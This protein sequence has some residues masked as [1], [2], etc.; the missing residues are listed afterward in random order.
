MSHPSKKFS[1]PRKARENLLVDFIDS[2]EERAQEDD[3]KPYDAISFL[4]MDTFGLG[5]EEGASRSDGKGDRGIDW[6][7]VS[8]SSATIYQFKGT[9]DF[10]RGSFSKPVTPGDLSDLRRIL[11]YLE[12][13]SQKKKIQNRRAKKFQNSVNIRLNAIEEAN[14][15][16]FFFTVNYFVAKDGLTDQAADEFKE[17]EE[18]AKAIKE[19]GPVLVEVRIHLR[20]IDDVL[21]ERWKQQNQQWKT[22]TGQN[23]EWITIRANDRG[24]DDGACSILFCRGIDLIRAYEDL[25]HRFFAPN[26]RC[27]LQ[28]TPVNSRIKEAVNT[29]KGITNFR[30]M[31]N[32]VTIVG[33]AIDKKSSPKLRIRKPGVVNG[34][35]TIRALSQA[36][37]ELDGELQKHFESNLYLLVRIFAGKKHSFSIDDLVVATNN[38]NKME[39]RN[40]R[41]NTGTQKHIE[42]Q[43]AK[44]GWFYERK[45]KAWE[46]FSESAGSWDTLKGKKASNFGGNAKANRRNLDNEVVAAAWLAFSGYSDIARNEKNKLFSDDKRYERIFELVPMKHGY[47]YDYKRDAPIDDPESQSNIPPASNMLIATLLYTSAKY[48]ASS[49]AETKRKFIERHNL[50]EHGNDEQNANLAKIPEYLSEL[51]MVSSPFL[52]TELFGY[53]FY[54][55]PIHARDSAARKVL[56]ETDIS[57]VFGSK[58]YNELKANLWRQP[59]KNHFFIACYQ[60]WASILAEFSESDA[61]RTD[62]L[63]ASSRPSFVHNGP[64]RRKLI[65]RVREY[66]LSMERRGTLDKKWSEP[67][68]QAGSVSQALAHF[69]MTS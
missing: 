55:I 15:D 39:A 38:Q 51:M 8:R 37:S 1:F 57:T 53:L 19:I 5:N 28:D 14:E 9:Q 36:Y 21:E 29:V 54:Q 46:A 58:N 59:E 20:L 18:R 13:I 65:G 24:I 26:V 47:D 60:M 4:C 50:A 31:N 16:V 66:D 33:E 43:F 63:N 52:F 27:Y 35:Q 17:I 7:R 12:T 42:Q 10:S 25:G 64:T 40:L 69:C 22:R 32:G 67:F 41:S 49:A 62:L 2:A 3:L 11:D 68:D 34:L 48:C 23:E 61:F 30:Y 6:F 45:E 56:N 44:L